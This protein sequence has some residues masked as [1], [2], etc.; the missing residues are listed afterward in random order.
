MHNLEYNKLL[1][2]YVVKQLLKSVIKKIAKQAF[3]K[4]T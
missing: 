2:N 3:N 1:N 4:K